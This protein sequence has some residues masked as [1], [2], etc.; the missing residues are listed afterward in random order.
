VLLLPGAIAL[1]IV[2]YRLR[3]RGDTL[4]A[5]AAGAGFLAASLAVNWPFA[6]F[7]MSPYARNWVF[8]TNAFGYYVR[9]SQYQMAWTLERYERTSMEFWLG[10]VIALVATILSMR[11]GM[12]WGDWMRRIQ[13]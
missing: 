5:I 7:M 2:L 1:D 8:T 9:P 13:R 10:M 12:L 4:K 11:I 3:D 6:Y